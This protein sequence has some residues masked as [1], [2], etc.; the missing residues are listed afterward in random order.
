MTKDV[1]LRDQPRAGRLVIGSR[2]D[3]CYNIPVKRPAGVIV[4]A[5]L[6]VASA[7]YLAV[8]TLLRLIDP[9]AVPLSLGAPFLHG[10]E[11]SGPYMFLIGA[12]VAGVVG[13]G[14]L[15]LSNLARRA[16]IVIAMA[17]M[18]MLIPKVSAE[19]GDFS[20]RFF[21]GAASIIIRMMI[22]WYLWQV[23]TAERFMR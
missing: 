19:T 21:F 8:L 4:V 14:L 18:L 1:P 20:P 6:F 17:G 22:V 10:L 15:R 3:L 5:A 16:A 11:T 12:V 9:E 2:G 13:W 23:W 7:V